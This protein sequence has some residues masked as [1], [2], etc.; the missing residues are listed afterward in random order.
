M[1]IIIEKKN[2]GIHPYLTV[3]TK[4]IEK[5]T[6]SLFLLSIIRNLVDAYNLSQAKDA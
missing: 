3:K 6:H 5:D 2:N 1:K 4:G